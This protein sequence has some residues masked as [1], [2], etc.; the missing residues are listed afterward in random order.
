MP[1]TL[2]VS[3]EFESLYEHTEYRLESSEGN[4]PLRFRVPHGVR[5]GSVEGPVLFIILYAGVLLSNQ[6]ERSLLPWW[7]TFLLRVP[8]SSQ[9]GKAHHV[10]RE[11]PHKWAG[12]IGYHETFVTHSQSP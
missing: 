8:N 6:E 4:P 9:M 7:I 5:Q 1:E 2:G 3:L 10:P 12:P 11:I